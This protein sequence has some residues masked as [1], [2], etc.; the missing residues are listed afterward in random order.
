MLVTDN[1]RPSASELV[2]RAEPMVLRLARRM[3]RRYPFLQIEELAAIGRAA[4][5]AATRLYDP[6]LGSFDDFAVARVRGE[7][8]RAAMREK[9]SRSRAVIDRMIACIVPKPPATDLGAALE[10]THD[11][12]LERAIEWLEA[13]A[14]ALL[15]GSLIAESSVA[16]PEQALAE[17][18]E[19]AL[20]K[21]AMAA[22]PEHERRTIELC[23]GGMLKL[24]EIA[25]ELGKDAR[26]VRRWRDS[27]AKKLRRAIQAR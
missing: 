13:E 24:P 14:A 20:A 5:L 15:V 9:T 10:E 18:Q 27:A 25:R 11:V 19:Q 8:V 12:A 16:D 6:A 22:L 21:G 7:M 1:A 26:T 3:R 4:A 17:A 23:A 2:R